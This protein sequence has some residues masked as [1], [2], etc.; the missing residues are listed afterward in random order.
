MYIYVYIY[1]CIYMY[2]YQKAS[3]ESY[4]FNLLLN[5]SIHLTYVNIYQ[6]LMI[7]AL[8]SRFCRVI[9]CMRDLE[10]E[11]EIASEKERERACTR[12]RDRER[13]RKR[14][15]STERKRSR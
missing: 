3:R 10:T 11:R 2:I 7:C 15:R 8:A 12:E 14:G 1:I 6:I 9:R 5:M 13:K 4:L